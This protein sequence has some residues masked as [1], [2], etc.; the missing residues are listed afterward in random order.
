M[1]INN[2]IT[3]PNDPATPAA[4][5]PQGFKGLTKREH[6]AAIALQGRMA[7][8]EWPGTKEEVAKHAVSYAD[9]LINALNNTNQ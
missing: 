3:R 4:E 5:G 2:P 8:P 9:A 6:F 7:S 1:N